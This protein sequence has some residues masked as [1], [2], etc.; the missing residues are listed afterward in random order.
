MTENVK[1]HVGD[2]KCEEFHKCENCPFKYLSCG[3]KGNTLYEILGLWLN[4]SNDKEIYDI[5]KKRLDNEVEE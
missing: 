2:K 3:N 5:L 1:K 4:R